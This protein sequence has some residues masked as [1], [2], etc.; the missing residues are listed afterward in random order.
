[1][2]KAL[3]TM[4]RALFVL[5]IWAVLS[6]LTV[7]LMDRAVLPWLVRHNR[8]IQVPDVV[9]M[10]LAEAESTLAQAGL[11]MVETGQ[12]Y[13]PF[14][15]AGLILSQSPE[16]GTSVKGRGRWIRVVV[17][18][19]G[20]EVSVPNLQGVSLRQAKLI[21]E[22]SGLELGQISWMY[23]ED[24]PDNVVISSAPGY[25]AE[26]PQGEIVDL[27]V[28][29]GSVPQNAIV[30]DFLGQSL[31]GA[32]LMARDAGLKIGKIDYQPDENLLPETVLK[33]S[34]EPGAEVKRDTVVNLLVS[35]IR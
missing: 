31:E 17:S 11:T 15:P 27:L 35:T 22:R 8:Q 28:S 2:S 5:A 18:R 3:G 26:V 14:I 20:E 16:E 6:T 33:Q 9:E 24:F 23:T 21:L 4:Q 12:E 34:V 1:M 32:V 7:L 29:Q 25:R 13:D 19:G 30:P 10:S